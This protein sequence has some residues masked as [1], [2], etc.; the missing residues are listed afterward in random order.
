MPSD[1]Y[2]SSTEGWPNPMDPLSALSS[3]KPHIIKD[4][5]LTADSPH[6]T[7]GFGRTQAAPGWKVKE[8]EK[9]IAALEAQ[10]LQ[11]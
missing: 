7:L 9:R 6:H 8:L 3:D 1:P 2:G 4:T 10:G 11:P 5:D